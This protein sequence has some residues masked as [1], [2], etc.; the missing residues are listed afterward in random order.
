MLGGL[1]VLRDTT[2]TVDLTCWDSTRGQCSVTEYDIFLFLDQRT[3]LIIY[4][5]NYLIIKI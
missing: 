2:H 5:E 1:K 4:K 3:D